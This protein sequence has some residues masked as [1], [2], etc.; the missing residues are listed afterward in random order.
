MAFMDML[1]KKIAQTGQETV[2]KTKNMAESVKLSSMVSD[3]EKKIRQLFAEI[4]EAYFQMYR[5]NPEDAFRP[6]IA[7]IEE[8][9]Q[10]IN[11]YSERIKQLK[12]IMKCPNCGGEVPIGVPFCNTC[13]AR[14]PQAAT[15]PAGETIV[16]S[17]CGAPQ[18]VGTA[19][20]TNCGSKMEEKQEAEIPDTVLCPH[21][22]KQLPQGAQFCSGCG[23]KV[24]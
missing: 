19:F 17:K 12:G 21:C 22:G 6:Y 1:G 15:P 24:G 2:Q 20:C 23:G 14:M 9:Q 4:G 3:E 16:C 5:V 18:A 10:K 7:Q 8:A 11:I 13:G